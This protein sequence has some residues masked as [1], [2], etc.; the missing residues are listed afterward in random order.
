MLVHSSSDITPSLVWGNILHEVMQGC[1]R[2]GQWGGEWIDE[3][4]ERVVRAGEGGRGMGDL[5]R[6][7]VGVEEAVREVKARAGGLKT[8]GERYMAHSPKVPSLFF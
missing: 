7:G 3:R 1:L 4:I 6:L 5:V 2:E 8:F